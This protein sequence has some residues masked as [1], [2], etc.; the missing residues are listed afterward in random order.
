[1]CPSIMHDVSAQGCAQ[2]PERQVA[3]ATKFCTVAPNICRP[4][5]WNLLHVTLLA[6]RIWRWF[7]GFW[8]ICAPLPEHISRCT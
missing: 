5:V 1:M 2:I 6:T 8:K 3:R 4:A 7:V